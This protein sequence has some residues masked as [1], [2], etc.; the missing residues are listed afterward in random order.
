MVKA[1]VLYEDDF[2]RVYKGQIEIKAYFFPLSTTKHIDLREVKTIYVEPQ[3]RQ[4]KATLLR[5][6]DWGMALNPIWWARD[7]KR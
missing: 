2:C 6:K 3:S 4:L 1:S 5:T 7:L